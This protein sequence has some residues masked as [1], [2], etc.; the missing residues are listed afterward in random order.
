MR[1]WPGT[2]SLPPGELARHC[3]DLDMG[4]HG[5]TSPSVRDNLTFFDRS[6]S[7]DQ[8]QAVIEELEHQPGRYGAL[9]QGLNTQLGAM[10]RSIGR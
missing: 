4:F 3:L 9:P 10:N 7:D 2:A 8:I 1:T 5:N 6:I